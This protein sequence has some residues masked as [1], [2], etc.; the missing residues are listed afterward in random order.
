MHALAFACV[1]KEGTCKISLLGF[2]CQPAECRKFNQFKSL[3]IKFGNI[4]NVFLGSGGGG[5]SQNT[6][7]KQKQTKRKTD[8]QF[9]IL[10]ASTTYKNNYLL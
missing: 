3:Q 2:L 10:D 4:L 5:G 7:F 1:A 9:P 6:K 8:K